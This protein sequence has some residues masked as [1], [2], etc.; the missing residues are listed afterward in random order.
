M[1]GMSATMGFARMAALT[2]EME[3]VFELLR[4]RKGGLERAAIDVLLECLDA[5]TGAVDA[6]DEE[7]EEKLDHAP[8]VARLKE[9]VRDRDAAAE[10]A[11]AAPAAAG[12][13][14]ADGPVVHVTVT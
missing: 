11:E 5:L 4:Q 7:G 8:L 13:V 2:H 12:P 14:E 1:K 3:N 10:E 6:I 9:L